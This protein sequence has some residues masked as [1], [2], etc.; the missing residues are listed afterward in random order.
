M[1]GGEIRRWGGTSLMCGV[2]PFNVFGGCPSWRRLGSCATVG[3]V[4][5]VDGRIYGVGEKV[6]RS[7]F[8]V[9]P[10]I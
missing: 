5:M 4:A 2:D 6:G 3:D 9:L 1:V 10:Q 8:A 7:G